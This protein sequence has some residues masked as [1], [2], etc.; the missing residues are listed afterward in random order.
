MY[1]SAISAHFRADTAHN[2]RAERRRWT[3]SRKFGLAL[4]VR[5]DQPDGRGAGGR[6]SNS[7]S[8]RKRCREARS[9]SPAGQEAGTSAPSG[10]GCAPRRRATVHRGKALRKPA[11][12]ARSAQVALA[13]DY[14]GTF[15]VTCY[16]LAGVTASGAY[17]GPESV[18]V[19]P[20]VIPLGAHVFIQGVGTRTADDTGGAIIG[21]HVDIWEPSYYQCVDWGVQQRAVYLVP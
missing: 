3:A 4:A 12:A 14:L 6:R 1:K 18:A 8:L 15:I 21:Q 16:D 20:R 17:A 11:K 10:Q 2:A 5:R 9:A 7:D 13:R 19:D